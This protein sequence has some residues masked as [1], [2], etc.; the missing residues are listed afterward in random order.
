MNF[1]TANLDSGESDME[2][3][4]VQVMCLVHL[5]GCLGL[6]S[7][8]L[9]SHPEGVRILVPRPTYLACFS[10]IRQI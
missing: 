1:G 9:E 10:D 6:T 7:N 4:E 2:Y 3:E 5:T 8:G